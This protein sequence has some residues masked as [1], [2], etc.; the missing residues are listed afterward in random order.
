MIG[1]RRTRKFPLVT[2]TLAA[3]TLLLATAARPVAAQSATNDREASEF[4]RAGEAAYGR[5]DFAAAARA[6]EEAHRRAPHAATLY[7]AGLAWELSPY[8]AAAMILGAGVTLLLLN[9]V[10]ETLAWR[11]AF[12]VGALVAGAM[13]L[14]RKLRP[15]LGDASM[16]GL[17]LPPSAGYK[18]GTNLRPG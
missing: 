5:A 8:V 18:R 14:A 11:L 1:S 4:F 16:V 9:T 7:N 10:A 2:V 3:I 15:L 12:A 17:W 6:F 13:I